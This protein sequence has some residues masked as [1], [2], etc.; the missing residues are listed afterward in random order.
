MFR[1]VGFFVFCGTKPLEI[2]ELNERPMLILSRKLNES[3]VINDKVVVTVLRVRGDNVL[4][5]IDAPL[6]IPVHRQELYD[7]MQNQEAAM[8]VG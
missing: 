7:K 2:C 4:L 3:I 8:A 1:Y 6:E 5:G